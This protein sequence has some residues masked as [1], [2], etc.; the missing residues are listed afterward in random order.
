MTRAGLFR[1]TRFCAVGGVGFLTDALVLEAVV[2]LGMQPVFAR[3]ISMA[4]ALCVTY[5][6]HRLITFQ[7]RHSTSWNEWLRFL[8][9]NGAGALLNYGIFLTMLMAL[10][11]QPPLLRRQGALVVA[12]GTALL[13]NYWANAQRVFRV[14]ELH[15]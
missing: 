13:F 14:R 7:V 5:G 9:W 11:G 1:F 12:T 10:D 6:L 15:S 2:R 4:A 8:M 3:L